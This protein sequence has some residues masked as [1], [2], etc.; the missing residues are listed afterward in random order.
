MIARNS[1]RKQFTCLPLQQGMTLHCRITKIDIER[2]KV[3]L[4]SKS[5]DLQDKNGEWAPP[6]DTYYDHDAA[7]KDQKK[8]EAEKKAHQSSK[9]LT[10]YIHMLP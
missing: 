1:P 10:C 8:G 6:K 5:S 7:E 2:F 9:D 3:D 4:T